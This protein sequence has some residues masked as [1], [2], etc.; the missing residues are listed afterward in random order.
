MQKELLALLAEGPLNLEA[1]QLKL[2]VADGK[3]FVALN[4]A[5][6]ELLERQEV[7]LIKDEYNLVSDY[8]RGVV[9]LRRG[10]GYLQWGNGE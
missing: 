3:A 6:N 2:R 5:L 1:L 9:R 7:V 8:L 4:K 10:K